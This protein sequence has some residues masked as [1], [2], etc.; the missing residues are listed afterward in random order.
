MSKKVKKD[1]AKTVRRLFKKLGKEQKGEF[2]NEQIEQMEFFEKWYIKP[3]KERNYDELYNYISKSR[4][5]D[6][7]RNITGTLLIDIIINLN[8]RIKKLEK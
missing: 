2:T 7:R 5:Y 3:E 4:G 8:N 6:K 1:L